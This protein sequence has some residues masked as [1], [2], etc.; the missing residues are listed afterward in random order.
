MKR[1]WVAVL[2]LAAITSWGMTLEE[3]RKK[4]P[5]LASLDDASF[6]DAVHQK[7]YPD[8]DK[9]EFSKWVGYTP[10][11]PKP[12]LGSIDQWRY[13]SCQKDAA[14]A[15]TVLGVNTGLRLCREKF[16]Q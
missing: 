9:T 5:I 6:V 10:P 12:K 7:Y 14:Q 1:I 13:E 4:L 2:G 3:A 16:G 15:P 8:M 11:P